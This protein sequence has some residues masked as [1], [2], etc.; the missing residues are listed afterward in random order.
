MAD[1]ERG[2]VKWFND[3]KGYGFITRNEGEDIFVHY[4]N[5][6]GDGHRT[7]VEGQTVEFISGEGRKGLQ[8]TEVSALDE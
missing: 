1:R 7:L 4:S 8:A 2:T 6:T 5:I 3:S